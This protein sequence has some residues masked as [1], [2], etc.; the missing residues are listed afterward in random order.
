MATEGDAVIIRAQE[1][2]KKFGAD[3]AVRDVSLEVPRGQIF[4]FIGPSG[5][6]KT[7]TIR[8]LTGYYAPTSGNVSVFGYP[9]THFTREQRA[10]IGYMPQLFV[11]YPHLSIWENLNFAASIYGMP[12]RRK[13]RMQ[14]VLDFVELFEHRKKLGRNISGGMQRRLSLAATLVHEPQLIFLDEPTA[15]IDPVLRQ[16][17]WEHF[18][19]LRDEGHTLFI[20]TQYVSEAAYCDLV[21]IINHG[22]LLTVDTPEGLRRRAYGGDVVEME[23]AEPLEYEHQSRLRDLP[24]V[25]G[26]VFRQTDGG[27][28]LVVDEASTAIPKLMSWCQENRC[29][30][31]SLEEYQ[32]PYEEVF[33]QII[34]AEE[35]R[36]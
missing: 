23:T 26:R 25:H 13:E 10:R 36:G 22:M 4:G 20:T 21:G 11:F 6:G 32:P 31:E 17:F 35:E 33:V 9:P 27:L 34:Q 3:V 14:E 24:F 28:R 1:L 29:E 19:A 15:S 8:M 5:S 16:K 7:T 12:L 30:V 18:R 2:A